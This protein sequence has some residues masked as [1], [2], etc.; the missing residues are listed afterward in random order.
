MTGPAPGAVAV[1]D[2]GKRDLLLFSLAMIPRL[3]GNWV[4][5]GVLALLIFAF[6]CLTRTPATPYAF[7]VAA[8]ASA[9]GAFGGVLSALT[10]NIVTML[11]K[12]GPDSALL[13]RHAYT[14]TPHGLLH[15]RA[16]AE[17]LLAWSGFQAMARVPGYLL[18]RVSA[19]Q[20]YLVPR[21]SFGT[22]AACHAF[23]QQALA[24]ARTAAK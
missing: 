13:G 6:V 4:F 18:F 7:L 15:Q 3:R 21:R 24:S 12:V 23:W 14:V 2:I 5:M 22:R 1:V 19:G 8:V 20:F 17:A 16:G 9:G 11:L 10:I